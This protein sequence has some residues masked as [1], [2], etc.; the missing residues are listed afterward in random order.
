M[1]FAKIFGRSFAISVTGLVFAVG[2]L[3]QQ[4]VTNAPNAQRP[5]AV[6]ERN[7]LYCAGYIQRAGIDASTQIVGANDE[8]DQHIYSQNEYVYINAGASRGVRVGDMMSV[9]RPRG[10]VKSKWSKKDNLGFYVQEVGAVE[11]VSVKG[12]VS[13][14]RIHTSCDNF[15]L[16]DLVQP[17][18]VRTSP[19]F[20]DTPALDLFRNPTG[21]AIGRLIMARDMQ[22]MVTRDQIVYVDLGVEDNV[23]IGDRMT[24][25]RPLGKGNLFIPGESETVAGARG[26]FASDEYRGGKFSNTAGRK[27][28]G[29]A[30]G[31]VVSE[32]KAKSSRPDDLRKVVGELVVLNVKERTATAVVVRTGQEIHTGDYVELQ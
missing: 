29:E 21:K 4:L 6:A 30:R 10:Q 17:T 14:A 19:L 23:R 27:S 8:A 9:V 24:V 1:S 7:N 18:Q 5:F 20:S 32:K 12:D 11:V 26:Q 2:A 28:G 15:L 13:V 25:F 22:E 31:D 3:G 16:G